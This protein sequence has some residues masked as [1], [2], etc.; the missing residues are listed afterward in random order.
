M[1]GYTWTF[2]TQDRTLDFSRVPP[3]P[4]MGLRVRFFA[5]P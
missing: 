4:R 5:A 2:P 3:E 1:R